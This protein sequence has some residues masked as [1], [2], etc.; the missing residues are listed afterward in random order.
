MSE[1]VVPRLIDLGHLKAIVNSG[2]PVVVGFCSTQVPSSIEVVPF[3]V[4][5]LE[6]ALRHDKYFGFFQVH[7]EEQRDIAEDQK[8]HK[9]PTVVVFNKREEVGRVVG[10]NFEDAEKMIHKLY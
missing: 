3:L 10:N 6:R 4:R 7:L 2:Q 9:V 5:E 8:V 1:T